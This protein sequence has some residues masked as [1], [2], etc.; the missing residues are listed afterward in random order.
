MIQTSE[1]DIYLAI[2]NAIIEQKL[3]PN[4]QLVEEVLAESFRVSRTPVRNVLRRLANENLVTV[5]PYKGTFVSC[6][7]I[8]EAKKVF[9]IRAV[10]EIAA[11]SQAVQHMNESNL[12]QLKQLLD[13]EHEAYDNKEYFD[14]LRYSGEFHLKLA[15]L[16]GN[17]YYTKFLEELI[18]LSYV[19][20]A[21]YGE[22][23]AKYCHDHEQILVAMT[24]GDAKLAQELMAAHLKLLESGLNFEDK[25]QPRALTEV[26][27]FT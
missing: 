8:E 2:K 6:P 17:A 5:I 23:D 7:T 11:I 1:N 24:D 16:S 18:S 26:F 10:L 19:I 25:K 13:Q 9:E 15:S 4:M 22:K 3:R 12:K 27:K 21:F 14:S 20:I